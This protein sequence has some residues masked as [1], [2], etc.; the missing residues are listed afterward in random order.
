MMMPIQS[1]TDRKPSSLRYYWLQSGIKL[2]HVLFRPDSKTNKTVT[3]G[4]ETFEFC[5]SQY[6]VITTGDIPVYTQGFHVKYRCKIDANCQSPDYSAENILMTSR[7]NISGGTSRDQKII[8]LSYER[9]DNR[10]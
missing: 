2:T 4:L 1:T 7:K 8:F 5:T 10:L 9:V 3:Y 6:F